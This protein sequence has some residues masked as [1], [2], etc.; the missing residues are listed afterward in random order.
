MADRNL[1]RLL[2][3]HDSPCARTLPEPRLPHFISPSR[4]NR[5]G[6]GP[7][8]LELSLLNCRTEPAFPIWIPAQGLVYSQPRPGA[9]QG[10]PLKN[11]CVFAP[12]GSGS[13]LSMADR[14]VTHRGDCPVEQAPRI[15]HRARSPGPHPCGLPAAILAGWSKAAPAGGTLARN[16]PSAYD[17]RG[18][19]GPSKWLYPKGFR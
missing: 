6:F 11:T 7:C 12:S 13:F 18:A 9:Q 1:P 10:M 8:P 14:T 4:R 15:R 19:A 2:Q 17:F 5:P 3:W 16:A